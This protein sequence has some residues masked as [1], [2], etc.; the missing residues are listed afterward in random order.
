MKNDRPVPVRDARAGFSLLELIIALTILAIG[1][2]GMAGTTVYAVQSITLSGLATDRAAARQAA[3]EMIMAQPYDSV[4][5][6][7]DTI[8]AY[9]MSWGVT[10]AGD[11][12]SVELITVGPGRIPSAD[13]S[14]PAGTVGTVTDTLTL[15]VLRP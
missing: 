15:T 11:W 9:A 4:A 6:R 2:L 8:G 14:S 1:T 3:T 5:A 12:K 10:N 13:G 7:S